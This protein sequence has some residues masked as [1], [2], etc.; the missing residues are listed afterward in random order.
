MNVK[1]QIKNNILIVYLK[2]DIDH[3][4]TEKLR[5]NIDSLID[6][7]DITT[8]IIDFK[9]VNFIDSSGIGLILGRYKKLSSINGKVEIVNTTKQVRKLLKMASIE[10]LLPVY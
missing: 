2:E 9:A 3:H 7:S 8:L 10:T 4:S 6:S 1:Y 5:L